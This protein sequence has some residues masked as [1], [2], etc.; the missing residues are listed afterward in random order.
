MKIDK[1]GN[2]GIGV[3]DPDQKL[4]LNG[5][6]HISEEQS[7]SPSAPINND[8]GIIYVKNDGNL[9]FSSNDIPEFNLTS[10]SGG[11]GSGSITALYVSAPIIT[12]GTTK[13]IMVQ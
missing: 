6:L 9:Y 3:S 10:T 8:G 2:V 12:D 1:D 7:F 11:G 4:E 13:L 5:I